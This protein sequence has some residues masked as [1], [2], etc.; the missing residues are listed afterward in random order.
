MKTH[1]SRNSFDAK[2][3]YSGIYQQ[4]GRMLTDADWNELADIDKSR[5]TNALIDV[6]G[7]GTPRER[8]LVGITE[9]PDGSRSYALQ[10]GYCYVD[11]LIAQVRPDPAATLSDASG[12]VFEYE[13]QADFP[14]APTLPGGDYRLYV[15]IW[16][17]TVIALE[18]TDLRDPG[19]H[20]ADTCTRTQTMAQV[21]WCETD[22]DPE[23]NVQNPSVG[24]A[25][26]TL[27]V[28]QGS[29]EPDPCDPCADEIALQD[30]LGNYLFRVEVHHVQY[31]GIS[32]QPQRVV[33]KW[34]SENGAEQHIID[35]EPPGFSSSNW[36]Y[37]FFDGYSDPDALTPETYDSEK[38]LG[39]HL[40]TA[41]TPARGELVNGYPGSAPSGFTAV[42]RWDGYC[43]LEK[44]GTE[45]VLLG[46]ADRGV[47]LSTSSSADAHGHVIE[48]STISINHDVMTLIIELADWQMLAGDFWYTVVRQTVNVAGETLLS[49]AE[50]AGIHHHYMLLGTISGGVFAPEE[51]LICQ[52]F[53]FPPL[54]D[55]QAGDVCYRVPDCGDNDQPTVAS[56]L[57]QLLGGD[58]PDSSNMRANV[59]QII[60]ALLCHHAATTLPVIKDET[61]CQS[62]QAPEIRSVQDALNLLCQREIDGCATYTVFPRP[63]WESVFDQIFDNQDASLCF[64]EGEYQLSTEK[65]VQGKGHLKISGA[66]P[67]TRI[68][69]STGETALRFEACASVTIRDMYVE[70]RSAG[71]AGDLKTLNGALTFQNC[72]QVHLNQVT[73]RNAAGTRPGA[74]C[75]TVRHTDSQ[76]GTAQIQGCYCDVG[77]QQ[78]GMLFLN[79]ERLTV[80]DNHIKTRPKPRSW[81]LQTQLG[82]RL[83]A[84]RARRLLI[85]NGEVRN[86][87]STRA[88]GKKNIQMDAVNSNRRIMIESPVA[89]NVWKTSLTQELGANTVASNQLL[90]NT[91]KTIAARVLTDPVYRASILPFENWFTALG[92]QNPSVAYKGIVCGG[93]TARDVRIL[94]NSLD[95]VQEG[96]HIGVSDRKQSGNQRY[97][98]G[99]VTIEGNTIHVLLPPVTVHRR[100]GIFC[101]NCNHLSIIDNHITIQRFSF[102]R[103]TEIEGIR[104]FGTMGRMFIVRQNYMS[105]C[106]I[107]VRVHPIGSNPDIN[108]QWMVADNMMPQASLAVV[109][110]SSVMK[111]NNLK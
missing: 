19:L 30:K 74:T 22:V 71:N 33:L 65:Q 85:N 25:K 60:D 43:E 20:G 99:R 108:N 79:M 75:L 66:G 98:A 16:E 51:S 7:S 73:L 56:L 42:R 81:T 86:F 13:H 105:N 11:G 63:G 39:K 61:L 69:T 62:L 26:L 18:D 54:T 59:R 96:I 44:S 94:N 72:A 37:E 91:A 83:F 50:P 36:V 24:N 58:F 106:T 100:G 111:T 107:G 46:G 78:I 97:Q 27:T 32:G 23:D 35:D 34:S 77:H 48:G 28:R 90:L 52:R 57:A 40:A 45:W 88:A 47:T 55:L 14:G 29:T 15:D 89:G 38:H 103:Q 102:S 6:I 12:I 53:G 84:A 9:N 1:I 95:G 8:G 80:R 92:S 49:T 93:R 104:I 109:A 67:G 87:E 70:A 41:F 17:R 3:R 68:I 4:M 110:P 5:V 2:K 101:G 10:W 64:R 76:T 21:K 31:D 82:D